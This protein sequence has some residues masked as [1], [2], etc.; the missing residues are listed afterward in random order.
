MLTKKELILLL[1]DSYNEAYFNEIFP[2]LADD[3][4][5]TSTWYTVDIVGQEDIIDYFS[6]KESDMKSQNMHY[7]ATYAELAYENGRPASFPLSQGTAGNHPIKEG[8]IGMLS[9]TEGD[10]VV[11]LRSEVNGP[12]EVVVTLSL[13]KDQLIQTINLISHHLVHFN[14]I[15]DTQLLEP[16]ELIHKATDFILKSDDL[17]NLEVKVDYISDGWV[18]VLQVKSPKGDYTMLLYVDTYPFFGKIAK[19]HF[20]L[21]AMTSYYHHSDLRLVLLQAKSISSHE[22][23]IYKEDEISFSI[24]H[25][26]NFTKLRF[27]R[28]EQA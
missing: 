6:Q 9:Y 5:R 17:K 20:N 1:I 11:I 19:E 27:E 3:V 25:Q 7:Y 8:S 26:Q 15:P 28:E 24:I 13:N 21:L 16:L 18:P 23:K 4:R 22:S 14:E 2:Y 10:P 12:I